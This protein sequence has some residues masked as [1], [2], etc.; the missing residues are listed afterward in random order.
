MEKCYSSVPIPGSPKMSAGSR[1]PLGRTVSYL[2]VGS[3]LS[4]AFLYAFPSP[5]V[6]Y[7]GI[8]LLHVGIGLAAILACLLAWK[9]KLRPKAPL[10]K[11]GWSIFA[12]GAALGIV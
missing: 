11:V 1:F 9:R 2:V 7:V 5:T 12:I 4:A 6:S 3:F 8:V 10:D